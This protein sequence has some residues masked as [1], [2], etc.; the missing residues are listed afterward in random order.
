MKITKKQKEFLSALR[1]MQFQ[2]VVTDGQ[3]NYGGKYGSYDYVLIRN[4]YFK[5]WAFPME[6]GVRFRENNIDYIVE[7][8]CLGRHPVEATAMKLVPIIKIL[9][10]SCEDWQNE[11]LAIRL[12]QIME[13]ECVKWYDYIERLIDE[14]DE[15]FGE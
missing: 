13:D 11:T 7:M 3:D 9:S 5:G 10:C 14:L 2:I 15:K 12:L 6:V 4:I 8:N 1:T